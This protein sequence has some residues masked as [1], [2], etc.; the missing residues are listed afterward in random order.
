MKKKSR[1]VFITRRTAL[2]GLL[3]MVATGRSL[4]MIDSV[5]IPR[6][7]IVPFTAGGAGDLLGRKLA[8][9]LSKTSNAPLIVENIS[10]ASGAIAANE[11]LKRPHDGA[12]LLLGNS[13][14]ICSTPLLIK[15]QVGFDPQ[16]DLVP[17]C[18]VADAPFLL[19]AR[20]DF[21]ANN[22]GELQRLYMGGNQHL[23]FATSEVGSGNH[24][25]GEAILQRLGLQG[26]HVP[27]RVG[28]QAIIDI[29]EGRVQ[30]GI[31]GF[32]NISAFLESN[33]VKVLCVLSDTPL[34]PLPQIRTVM[35]QGFG[36]FDI[37]GWYALFVASGTSQSIIKEQERVM[38]SIFD[39]S[40][41]N[42]FIK[43]MGYLPAFRDRHHS[44][45]YVNDEIRRY[46]ELLQQYKVI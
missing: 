3:G 25:A 29:V 14:L 10:G 7:V 27:Y 33:K 30:L 26:T 17:I 9:L 15:G 5:G 37:Q 34:E 45:A 36:K 6:T 32:A 1:Q 12:A 28:S 44:E 16:V 18:T 42:A 40:D 19:F 23:T 35:A 24:L 4:G 43:K 41:I 38:K 11:L 31:F 22:L 8:Q 20:K 2:G 13:G 39:N 21:F 46:K